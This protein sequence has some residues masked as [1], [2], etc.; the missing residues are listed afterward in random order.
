M[1]KI[2]S[3]ILL[4]AALATFTLL[5]LEL[6]ETL[7]DSFAQNIDYFTHAWR[8]VTTTTYEMTGSA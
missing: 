6:D 7:A 5:S 3:A 1:F 8:T 2:I 4:G